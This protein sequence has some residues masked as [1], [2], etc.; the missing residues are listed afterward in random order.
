MLKIQCSKLFGG[1][2]LCVIHC[3]AIK[4]LIILFLLYT[5]TKNTVNVLRCI[6]IQYVPLVINYQIDGQKI[7]L[8]IYFYALYEVTLLYIH[9]IN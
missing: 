4:L 7:K 5:V 2:V 6:D 3:W 9:F 8:T 1:P